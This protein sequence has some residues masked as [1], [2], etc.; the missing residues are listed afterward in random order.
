MKAIT[1]P[2]EV[3]R[4]KSESLYNFVMGN[5]AARWAERFISALKM[6]REE[7][8]AENKEKMEKRSP[9]GLTMRVLQSYHARKKRLL[10]FSYDGT[11]TLRAV[12]LLLKLINSLT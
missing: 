5:S 2:A 4:M 6:G 10:L 3:R 9:A 11:P 12:A 1:M 8:K 7:S